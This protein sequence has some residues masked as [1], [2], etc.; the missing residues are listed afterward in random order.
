MLVSFLQ[1]KKQEEENM[2]EMGFD[3]DGEDDDLNPIIGDDEIG[4]GDE[5]EYIDTEEE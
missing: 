1:E 5:G 4:N 2:V 3:E